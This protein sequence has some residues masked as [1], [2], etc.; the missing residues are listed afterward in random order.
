MIVLFPYLTLYMKYF[1]M[2]LYV[3]LHSNGQ[4]SHGIKL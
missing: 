3:N 1:S 2:F 4:I